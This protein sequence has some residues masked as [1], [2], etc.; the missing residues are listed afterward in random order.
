LFGTLKP[1]GALAP[2]NPGRSPSRGATSADSDH[3]I[4]PK[5]IGTAQDVQLN[6]AVEYLKTHRHAAR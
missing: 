3:P 2:T 5:I 6:A 4:N 1:T